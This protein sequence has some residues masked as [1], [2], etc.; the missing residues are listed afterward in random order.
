M[1]ATLFHTTCLLLQQFY[2]FLGEPCAGCKQGEKV[3]MG[4]FDDQDILEIK[5]EYEIE[6]ILPD[7]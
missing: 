6:N 4:I 1:Q 5:K 3:R 7:Y 2:V